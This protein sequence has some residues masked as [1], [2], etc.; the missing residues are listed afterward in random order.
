MCV[1]DREGEVCD[2]RQVA[3]SATA[4]QTFVDALRDRADGEAQAVRTTA[5]K[6]FAMAGVGR[7]DIDVGGLYDCFPVTMARDLEEMGFCKLGEGADYIHEGHV[8]LGGKMPCNTDGGL[9]SHS[10]NGNPSGLQI[11][12]V[13]KQLRGECGARQVEGAKI[14]VALSQ[15]WAVHGLAGTVILA[16]D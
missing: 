15:G 3:H 11:T 7:D 6:A 8:R 14:G 10:H 12:E 16:V 2:R 5:N 9:L 4:L 1:L 13:T